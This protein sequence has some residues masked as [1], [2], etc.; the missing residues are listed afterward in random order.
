M[1][2][3]GFLLYFSVKSSKTD[4]GKYPGYLHITH[5][6]ICCMWSKKAGQSREVLTI[7]HFPACGK[8]SVLVMKMFFLLWGLLSTDTGFSEKLQTLHLQRYWETVWAWSWTTFCRWPCLSRVM[9]PGALQWSLKVNTNLWFHKILLRCTKSVR[10]IIKC[11]EESFIL[12][13]LSFEH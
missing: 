11:T 10:G 7:F 2:F 13:Q 8:T 1:C 5:R 9:E 6:V 12:V 4:P 3:W